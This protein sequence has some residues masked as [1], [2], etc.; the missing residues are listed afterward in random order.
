MKYMKRF[1]NTANK[2]DFFNDFMAPY[3]EEGRLYMKVKLSPDQA[4]GLYFINL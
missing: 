3:S 2:H 4:G 1:C